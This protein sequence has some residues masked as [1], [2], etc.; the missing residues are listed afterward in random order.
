M[1]Y[2]IL[3][4]KKMLYSS[5][6]ENIVENKFLWKKGDI[7]LAKNQCQLCKYNNINQI[8]KCEYYSDGKPK[9]IISNS[10]K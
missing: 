7:K 5:S 9:E 2:Y 4:I 3:V 10:R 8:D 1:K 6:Q